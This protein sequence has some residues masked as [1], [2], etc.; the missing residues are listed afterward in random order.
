MPQFGLPATNNQAAN[1][2]SSSTHSVTPQ[3]TRVK[4]HESGKESPS[5]R[6]V[7]RSMALANFDYAI[8]R[9]KE[10]EALVMA[11]VVDSL[12]DLTK[13]E[14]DHK[15]LLDEFEEMKQ[16]MEG[17]QRFQQA[18]IKLNVGGDFFTTSVQTITMEEGSMLAAMFSGRYTM[19]PSKD[20]GASS[21]RDGTHFRS[22][23]NYLR[24]CLDVSSLN[25]QTKSEL[26]IEASY[27]Q[28]QGLMKLIGP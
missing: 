6:G 25:V 10:Q 19:V 28:L 11:N 15:R 17:V 4:C 2:Y 13:R 26:L 9:L 1:S 24:G 5:E 14:E 23:L 27:Y 16:L 18:C 8:K 20:D 12:Q 22:I 21:D 7:G 3:Q